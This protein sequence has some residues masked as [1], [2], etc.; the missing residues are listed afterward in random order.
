[1]L[2]DHVGIFSAAM[3]EQLVRTNKPPAQKSRKAA[4]SQ[5]MIRRSG[6]VPL[7]LRGI[8]AAAVADGPTCPLMFSSGILRL[9]LTSKDSLLLIAMKARPTK[10]FAQQSATNFP[11]TC[12]TR[13]SVSAH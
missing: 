10:K 11:S 5:G 9:F 8:V 12:T 1:M 3:D 2:I 13:S 6:L 4:Q 7:P